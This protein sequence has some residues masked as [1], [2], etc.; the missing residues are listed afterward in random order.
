[1]RSEETISNSSDPKE[2][3]KA[4]QAERAKSKISASA[5]PAKAL[6]YESKQFQTHSAQTPNLE[7]QCLSYLLTICSVQIKAVFN[8]VAAVTISA[9]PITIDSQHN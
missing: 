2:P 3:G 1:M 7:W 5:Q 9:F 8:H 6:A 4:Q